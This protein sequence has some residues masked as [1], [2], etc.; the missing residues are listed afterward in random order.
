MKLPVARCERLSTSQLCSAAM[1]P[2]C[3]WDNEQ[4]RCRMQ[5]KPAARTWTCPIVNLTSQSL[6]DLDQSFIC[7]S[8]SSVDGGWTSWSTESTC[9][10]VTGER[11]RC[12]T[13]TCS[14][15]S[16]EN[17]GRLCQGAQLEISQC[18]GK[19]TRQMFLRMIDTHTRTRHYSSRQ[20]GTV[21]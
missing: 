17:G 9:E 4:Q 18:E 14:Q 19:H 1:D 12:R 15:P 6:G 2:Y 13:R 21:E 8:L 5:N 20:L 3:S 7:L 16:P 11:C 10:Q